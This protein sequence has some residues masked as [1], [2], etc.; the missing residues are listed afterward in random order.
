MQCAYITLEWRNNTI[1]FNHFSKYGSKI[2]FPYGQLSLFCDYV[3][4]MNLKR[5]KYPLSNY[6]YF[7]IGLEVKPKQI[8][9][10]RLGHLITTVNVILVS[11]TGCS[12]DTQ[13]HNKTTKLIIY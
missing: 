4:I 13:I 8:R 2:V 3:T 11:I 10:L 6:L 7:N 9:Q 1:T 5:R 12:I